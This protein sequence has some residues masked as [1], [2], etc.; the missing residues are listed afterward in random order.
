MGELLVIWSKAQSATQSVRLTSFHA[1]LPA[2]GLSR[3]RRGRQFPAYIDG[4]LLMIGS[5]IAF[6]M[7]GC[8][9]F[10]VTLL[11][12]FGFLAIGL[13]LT[14]GADAAPADQDRPA[15]PRPPRSAPIGGPSA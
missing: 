3:F 5:S 12:I 11:S 10:G 9:L 8:A 6:T 4:E 7:V 2:V 1:N 13:G 14:E 15:K